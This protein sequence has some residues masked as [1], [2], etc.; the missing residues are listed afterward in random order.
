[1]VLKRIFSKLKTSLNSNLVKRQ[2][3]KRNRHNRTWLGDGNYSAAYISRLKTGDII[4]V[5]HHTY[6][7]INAYSS[8]NPQEFLKIGSYCSI[9]STA[10]FMLSGEHAHHTIST[11]PFKTHICGAP[12]E[13]ICKG[14][15]IVD[16]DVWVGDS[17]LI[18]SG[19]HIG[20]GAVV[21]AG[22]IVTK[23]VPPY[24]IVGGVPAKIIKYRFSPELVEELMK[25]DFSELD[26]ST[27]QTHLDE[28]YEPLTQPEQLSWLPKR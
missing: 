28:L 10:R 1:M 5:G 8:G 13:A 16:D 4:H 9:A 17:A 21:A 12:Y 11:F 22:S 15:I 20:Q 2:W 19:V 23:D 14:S 24:A 7:A 27:L 25:I 6:G 26:T 3:K 18:L